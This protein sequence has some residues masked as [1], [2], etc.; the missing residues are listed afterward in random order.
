MEEGNSLPSSLSPRKLSFCWSVALQGSDYFSSV[1]FLCHTK[2]RL[3]V[4]TFEES[5]YNHCII[6]V[7]YEKKKSILTSYIFFFIHCKQCV[8]MW[9]TYV[10]ENKRL[11]VNIS[12]VSRE[13][14]RPL[15]ENA[16]EENVVVGLEKS[17]QL[18][19]ENS[20]KSKNPITLVNMHC[21]IR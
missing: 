21:L 20:L 1:H 5:G 9:E 14:H 17:A 3:A 13:V 8:L 12:Q 19:P 10:R 6:F 16:S 7:N 4:G 18:T 15:Q 11:W 2:H